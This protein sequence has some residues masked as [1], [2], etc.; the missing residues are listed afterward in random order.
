MGL[1]EL[2]RFPTSFP[3]FFSFFIK[4]GFYLGSIKP[5]SLKRL[6]IESSGKAAETQ[7][8]HGSGAAK[9]RFRVVWMQFVRGLDVV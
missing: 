4:A 6:K 1:T 8:R 2:F 5:D 3:G 9:T 7:F